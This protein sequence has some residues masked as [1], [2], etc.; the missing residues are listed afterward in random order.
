MEKIK[1]ELGDKALHRGLDRLDGT[2]ALREVGEA[3]RGHFDVENAAKTKKHGS[4][5]TIA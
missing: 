2:Y 3:S 1:H 4:W 5:E